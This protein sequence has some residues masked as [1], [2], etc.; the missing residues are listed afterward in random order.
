MFQ[1]DDKFVADLYSQPQ[2][3]PQVKRRRRGKELRDR[4]EKIDSPYC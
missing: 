4:V 3:L 2:K 1:N